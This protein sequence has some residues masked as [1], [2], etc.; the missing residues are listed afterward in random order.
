MLEISM[1]QAIELWPI[2]RLK[3]YERNARTHSPAQVAKIAAAITEFG[4]TNPILV[5]GN[6]GIIAGHGRLMAAKQLG[7]EQ[8]PVIELTYL[9][10]A[11]RRAYIIADNKLAEEAGWDGEILAAELDDLRDED[12]DLTLIGFEKDELAELI[13]SPDDPKVGDGGLG[14]EYTQKVTIPVYEPKGDK[15]AISA[16]TD[17]TKA[18]ELIRDIQAS[19]LSDEEKAFMI[20]A[21]GR[22]V[23]FDYQ[24]IAEYYCHASPEMQDLMERSVLV[25]IDFD[26]AV[27]GGYVQMT[28]KLEGV[29][30]ESYGDDE[31]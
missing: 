9:T 23:V 8:V 19:G 5:D 12:F 30:T 10:D 22:H 15:P 29:Y 7:M 26:K 27:A 6:D 25:L 13:G 17:D 14:D 16:L 28:Q 31:E 21:A 3:P 18:R 4:F 24:Q 1:A 20:Q 11:Q 2:D